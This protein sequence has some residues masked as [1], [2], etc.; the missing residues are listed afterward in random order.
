MMVDESI[1]ANYLIYADGQS[2]KILGDDTIWN[3]SRLRFCLS[4]YNNS[5][6][7]RKMACSCS[8]TIERITVI[9]ISNDGVMSAC[10]V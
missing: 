1:L 2:F 9:A 3:C 8:N 7:R 6:T 5:H 10:L 4:I